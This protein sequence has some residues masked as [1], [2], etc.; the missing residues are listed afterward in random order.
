MPKGRVEWMIWRQKS[1]FHILHNKDCMQLSLIQR[2]PTA[3]PNICWK[4]LF[5][6]QRMLH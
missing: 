3:I 6:L 5:C 1:V 4:A 2:D